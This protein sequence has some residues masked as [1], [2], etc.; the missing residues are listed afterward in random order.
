MQHPEHAGGCKRSAKP[1]RHDFAML[2]LK[3]RYARYDFAMLILKARHAIGRILSS[4]RTRMLKDASVDV[5][6]DKN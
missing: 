1:L 3:A 5:M 2:I 4:P 6:L